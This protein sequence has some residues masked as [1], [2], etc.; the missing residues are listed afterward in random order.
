[1]SKTADGQEFDPVTGE[2]IEH[3]EHQEVTAP[4]APTLPTQVTTGAELAALPEN[5]ADL[6]AYFAD[7]EPS[8]KEIVAWIAGT[9][10]ME[11][12]DPE[13]TIRSIMARILSATTTEGILSGHLVTHAQ[14][15]LDVPLQVSGVKWQ[16]SRQ[17]GG[18]TCYA[19]ISATNVDTEEKL[20]IT[21]GGRNVMTQLLAFH[22][23][24]LYPVRCRITQARKP[25]ENGYYPLWLEPV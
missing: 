25:T 22:V 10:D 19:V 17:D 21:C 20:T 3:E 7:P 9:A 4:A 23:H 14:Q 1:M 15:I 2:I 5:L 12:S 24:Q 18:S 6:A 13:D 8:P 16:R 11:E